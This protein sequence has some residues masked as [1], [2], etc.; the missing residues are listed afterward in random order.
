MIR[1]KLHTSK[2]S[3]F[4]QP[5]H[6]FKIQNSAFSQEKCSSWKSIG[7]NETSIKFGITYNSVKEI[8]WFANSKKWYNIFEEKFARTNN[9]QLL[10]FENIKI[11]FRNKSWVGA[12]KTIPWLVFTS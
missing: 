9:K 10:N 1:N 11:T 8:L 6:S 12:L 4:S 5:Q 2:H 3:I 7:D